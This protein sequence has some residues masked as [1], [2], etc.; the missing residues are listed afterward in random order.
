M[1]FN[2]FILIVQ[3]QLQVRVFRINV[4]KKKLMI[5][6]Q[7]RR[8]SKQRVLGISCIQDTYGGFTFDGNSISIIRI[9][10]CILLTVVYELNT[11]VKKKKKTY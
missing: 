6:I 4:I 8:R 10:N 2:S 3:K 1:K 7:K 9:Y 5:I 11:K